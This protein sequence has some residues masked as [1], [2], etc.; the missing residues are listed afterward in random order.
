MSRYKN[1][2]DWVHHIINYFDFKNRYVFKRETLWQID[3]L[4]PNSRILFIT[5][6]SK[7]KT[8]YIRTKNNSGR[9]E[10]VAKI[11]KIDNLNNWQIHDMIAS[12]ESCVNFE[13]A[14]YN[15]MNVASRFGAN[16]ISVLSRST[17][18][19]EQLEA[20]GFFKIQKSHLCYL[21]NY[22]LNKVNSTSKN[23]IRK[24]LP[25]DEYSMF[26][27]YNSNKHQASAIV[28]TL[29]FEHWK[30]LVAGFNSGFKEFVVE[31]HGLLVCCF[32]I[33]FDANVVKI[34]ILSYSSLNHDLIDSILKM[35]SSF[36]NRTIYLLVSGEYTKVEGVL[37][38]SGLQIVAE[39]DLSIK[40]LAN[41]IDNRK[42]LKSR[43]LNAG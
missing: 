39:Y 2:I 17:K 12:S 16:S 18:L 23:V 27:L 9:I 36:N 38:E 10:S 11:K 14:I 3:F 31:E 34:E 4:L 22:N 7:F 6:L 32:R 37:L 29:N 5:I 21:Q 1:I 28:H 41:F 24:K 13:T 43:I 19:T 33:K 42:N 25:S 35:I 30:S 8:N 40:W 15:S 26:Q 20:L